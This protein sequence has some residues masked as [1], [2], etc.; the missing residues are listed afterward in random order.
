MNDLSKKTKA[1]FTLIEVL[2]AIV[3]VGIAIASLLGANRIF[4]NANQAGLEM[5]TAEFL[6]EQIRELIAMTSYDDLDG[7]DGASFSPPVNTEQEVLSNFARYTQLITVENVSASDMEQVVADGSS[8]FI[9]VT[10]QIFSNSV[11]VSSSSWI[12]A[13]Y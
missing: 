8:D 11:E 4:T 9:R 3:F 10:V 7:F 6:A 13:N 2:L 12:R 5:S 1:G